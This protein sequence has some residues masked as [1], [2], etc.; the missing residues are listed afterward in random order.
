MISKVLGRWLLSMVIAVVAIGTIGLMLNPPVRARTNN[1]VDW[2]GVFPCNTPSLQQCI[3]GV[4]PGDVVHIK[5]GVYTQSVTLARPVSLIGDEPLT[6]IL[7]AEPRQRV[8]TVTGDLSLTTVISGLTFTGGNLA[9][10][11]CPEAC[12]G[13]VLI[14]DTARPTLQNL[15]LADNTAYQGSGMWVVDGAPVKLTNVSFIN[16]SAS[17]V[18]GG[19]FSVSDTWLGNN[20]FERNTSLNQ[21]GGAYV[22]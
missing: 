2:P 17:D 11:A 3:D 19:L 1:V 22:A 12:G 4:Q 10:S 18:G 15:L 13:A 20:Y 16:N 5:P 21:G 7:Y 6:T 14:T 8:L 9:G